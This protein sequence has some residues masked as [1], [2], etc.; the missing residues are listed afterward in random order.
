MQ[1]RLPIT[2]LV[3]AL[4]CASLAP[5]R[6]EA[7]FGGLIKKAKEKVAEKTVEKGAEQAGEKMGP[8][9][10]GE[11][12]TDDLL[13]SVVRGAQA[14]DRVLADRDKVQA[15]REAKNKELSVLTEKNQ[16]VHQAYDQANSKILDCR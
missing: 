2:A 7:Q 12:L 16:P 1:T 8:V 9:A 13:G 10:P 14:A 11:Q 15:A 5:A 3:C 6:A 4:A